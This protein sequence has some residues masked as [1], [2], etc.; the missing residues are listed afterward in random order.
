LLETIKRVEKERSQISQIKERL[1]RV[2]SVA[3]PISF[4]VTVPVA[5]AVSI[6]P[7]VPISITVSITVTVVLAIFFFVEVILDFHVDVHGETGIVELVGSRREKKRRGN[8]KLIQ[9]P[10]GSEFGIPFGAFFKSV[11]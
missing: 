8:V 11:D 4:A 1:T 5:V 7:R 3:V 6:T 10:P 9:A 2:P